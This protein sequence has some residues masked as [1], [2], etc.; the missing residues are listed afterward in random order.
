M[1][2]TVTDGS[3][4]TATCTQVVTV[5]DTEDPMITCPGD[6]VVNT[7]TGSCT[8]TSVN[9]GT[10]VVSDNC[11]VASTVNDGVEP[12]ALGST[13]VIWTVTDGSGNTATCIQIVT[14][15]DT[16]DPMITC[17]FDVVVDTDSGSCTATGVNLGTPVA[18]D[19]CAISNIVND[20]VEPYALGGTDVMWTVT[21]GSGNTATCTQVVTVNDTEDPMITC[22]GD[23]VVDTDSGSCTATGVNLGTPVVSDNCSVASTVNDAIEPY[24]LGSTD[25]IWTVTDG[26]GNTATC[27]QVVTVND[28]EDPMITCPGDVVVDTDSG[29]CTATGVNLGTPIVSDNCSVSSTVNDGVEPYALGSTDVIWTVTDGSGNTATCTQVVTVNDT[30][31]PMITCPGDVVVDTDSGICT[32]TG[33]NLGTPA[34]SDN[35]SVASTVND[36]VEPYALGSTDVIWTVTDGSGNTAT[37]TQVVTVNDTEDPMITCPGDVVVDTDSGLC[38]ATGVNLGTPVVSDNCSVASTVNDGVEP[39]AL[40]STDVIWTVT[41]G[42]G[43]TATCTQVVTVNDTEDPMIT[44]PGD[45]VVDTD[46]G[47]CT[48][49]GVNLGTPVVSDNCSVASTVNDGVEPYALGSTDVIWTVTDGSGNTATC[50]QVVTVN[51]TEDPIITCPSDVVVDTDSGSCTATGVNLGTPVVSDNCSV[52]STVNDGVEPY[53]LGNTDVI[54]TVTDGSGNTATC[55]Q[56]VTVNDTEDPMITCPAD[57]VVDTDSGS[58]T[59]TGVNL[60]TPVVSDNCSVASTVNDAIEPYALGST[61][62][63]WTVTDGS[64]NTSTCTQVVT[65]NDTEDPMITCPADVVVD[66]DPG[67]CTATGVNLG[68]P[69]VSD[70]CSVAST[71]NDAIEPYA[72]GSTDVIWTVTDGSGNTATCTQVVTVNDT[73]DPMITCPA[74]VVV[75]TDSGMCTATGVNLGTPVVSDNCSVA[76][77]VNDAIEPYALGSTDVMWTVTDGSGNTATCTQV[78]T[79]NDTEDPMITCPV[80]VVVDT[81]SGMCTATGVNL[82]TPIV[83]DN[84]SVA[85][86]VNDAI[87]PYALGSTDVIWTVTDGSGNTATCTQVVTVNDTEDPMIT[88]PADVVVNTDPG[89]CTATGINLG[90]PVVSDNCS[91]ASTVNDGVEPYALGSTDVIWT[92]TDGSGNTA[93]CTQVVTVNDT[94]DP[95][96]TC[97]ADVVVDT[98]SGSCTAT[99]VNLGTPVVSDNCSVASTVNDAIEPYALGSTDVIWTVTDGSGNTATCTQVVTVN[100]TEDPMITCPADVVVDT[101]SGLCTA[102]GVN[103]GTPVVSDN[104]SVS[105]T[106]NDAS[107][108]MH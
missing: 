80:D 87:E 71:V 55:T 22:P 33:V 61:D 70:N 62:V 25:V 75:D 78:V 94:E 52:A 9:L 14:V 72:L 89:L 13:D 66:T 73:E 79:V 21:D 86:T 101:D 15:N 28:T 24:A 39:Y 5:N 65:V 83:S 44:C 54:W 81:D 40:G 56:V 11:S 104:C 49:T 26:S 82:G 38:T 59:A 53:A 10:P 57:V 99:G 108:H 58:C 51:D 19:N 4:N 48:A 12:Y 6:V 92:V 74:D 8:A 91:V 3:G 36:G 90:T 23:V 93:T 47:L 17:P 32:A 30:E 68:T 46:S 2:W 42:S 35:C 98:D 67:L 106:V 16:E 107:S 50:T 96:I 60:G 18:T 76:S 95:M 77:T 63:I 7:D 103:L 34:V 27:T 85:S 100:D 105:S 45:V 29:S 31:D 20:G 102:T 1:I 84:C 37:C 64:G 41:D 88:C 97:P 43:N 69:V